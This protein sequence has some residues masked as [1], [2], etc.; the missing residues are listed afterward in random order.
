MAP[1]G[2]TQ[3][4]RDFTDKLTTLRQPGAVLGVL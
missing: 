2:V 1:Y 4:L 3:A